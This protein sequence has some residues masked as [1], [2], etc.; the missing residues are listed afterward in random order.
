MGEL[1]TYL[2]R[3]SSRTVH[4]QVCAGLFLLVLR[5][6]LLFARNNYDF[7]N[8]PLGSGG[9]Q[10]SDAGWI[11]YFVMTSDQFFINN[12]FFLADTSYLQPGITY[13]WRVERADNQFT[14]Q[15]FNVWNFTA[16]FPGFLADSRM[17][18]LRNF[19]LRQNYPIPFNP[20]TIMSFGIPESE[21]VCL[22]VYDALGSEAAI[23]INQKVTAG[24]YQ[25]EWDA[26]GLPSGRYFYRIEAGPFVQTRQMVLIK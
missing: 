7:G 4:I 5:T 21:W 1:Y 12:F 6:G 22:T 14:I 16:R 18:T 25:V 23:L 9:G 20:G 15:R 10:H 26:S 11:D 17:K 8:K 13:Q 2:L 19:S 3:R 24:S